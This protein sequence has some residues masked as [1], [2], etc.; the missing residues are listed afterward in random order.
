[1]EDVFFSFAEKPLKTL[2][3]WILPLLTLCTSFLS[4]FQICLQ[5]TDGLLVTCNNACIL[6]RRCSPCKFLV[7]LFEQVQIEHR[8]NLSIDIYVGA[9]SEAIETLFSCMHSFQCEGKSWHFRQ[10]EGI[11]IYL[12]ICLSIYLSVCLSV[13]VCQSV[14]LSVC[15][16]VCLSLSIYLSIYP[17]IYPFTFPSISYHVY[18]HPYHIILYHTGFIFYFCVSMYPCVCIYIDTYMFIHI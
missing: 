18:L 15:L 12:S 4:F 8:F 10:C 9:I 17:S 13:S 14:S 3:S 16:S 2:F 7:G 1:M 6:T 11:S 5:P